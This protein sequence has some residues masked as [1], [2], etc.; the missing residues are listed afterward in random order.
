MGWL[1]L[2]KQP[3]SK[4]AAVLRHT[5]SGVGT[6]EY[7]EELTDLAVGVQSSAAGVEL[8]AGERDGA[9]V[10]D[11]VDDTEVGQ[12]AQQRLHRVHRGTDRLDGTHEPSGTAGPQQPDAASLHL[13]HIG[14][15]FRALFD[16]IVSVYF[17]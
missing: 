7:G 6:N 17:I 1:R 5:R 16:K 15:S 9:R 14:Y 4:D 11:E 13:Q 3:D 2:C 10:A 12:Q 8:D